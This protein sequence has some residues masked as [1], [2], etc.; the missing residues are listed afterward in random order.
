M[1]QTQRSKLSHCFS[2]KERAIKADIEDEVQSAR[3]AMARIERKA[4]ASELSIISLRDEFKAVLEENELLEE[5]A[6]RRLQLMQK[7]AAARRE[8]NYSQQVPP[9]RTR[10]SRDE[11]QRGPAVGEEAES[12]CRAASTR[13]GSLAR[14]I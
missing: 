1:Y 11:D 8:G 2:V 7:E 6:E 4:D 9:V 5:M 12:G 13:Y 3:D 14:Y 10:S